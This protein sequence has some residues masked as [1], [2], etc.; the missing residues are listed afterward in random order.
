MV[1]TAEP[2]LRLGDDDHRRELVLEVLPLH[3][4]RSNTSVF[5]PAVSRNTWPMHLCTAAW[6]SGPA[7]RTR[8]PLTASAAPP[9]VPTLDPPVRRG[10][11]RCPLSNSGRR[12]PVRPCAS[13]GGPD[14]SG[15]RGD[16]LRTAPR[17]RSITTCWG[18]TAASARSASSEA[19]PTTSTSACAMSV[20]T[21]AQI[22]DAMWGISS[23]MYRRFAPINR[24]MATL[25][26]KIRT[27]HPLPMSIS[28][29][30]TMGLSRRSS[31]PG[32]KARPTIP[33]RRLRVPS[34][35]STA[36][37]ICPSFEAGLRRGAGR[38]HRR[39]GRHGPARGGPWAGTSRRTRSPDAGT[40]RT[41]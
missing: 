6:S 8:I 3:S 40:P 36:R 11:P 33:I 13:V 16:G 28:T 39:P 22:N 1:V 21:S 15:L 14:P 5:S 2:V 34:T 32:L 30:A 18:P 26:S 20:S 4:V 31:V 7:S 12:R 35:A 37:R 25:G 9:S 27:S 41:R 29:S 17:V 19:L 38:G 10:A 23:S 24:A